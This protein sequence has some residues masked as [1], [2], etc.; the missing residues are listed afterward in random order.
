MR[1]FMW[2]L[3]GTMMGALFGS[4]ITLLLTPESGDELQ[5]KARDRVANLRSELQTAYDSRMEQMQSE[6][7][8]MSQGIRE[9]EAE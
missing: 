4:V 2:F 3:M 5:A 8:K 7:Q 9:E 6:F 1:Q